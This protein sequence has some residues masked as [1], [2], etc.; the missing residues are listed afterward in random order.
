MHAPNGIDAMTL[1]SLEYRRLLS[2]AAAEYFP[3][4]GGNTWDY[5]GVIDGH[6]NAIARVTSARDTALTT[7]DLTQLAPLPTAAPVL[8]VSQFSAN[9]TGLYLNLLD[10]FIDNNSHGIVSFTPPVR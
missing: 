10:V 1:E 2:Y 8:G 9:A 6:A 3:M 4:S 7:F 5:A